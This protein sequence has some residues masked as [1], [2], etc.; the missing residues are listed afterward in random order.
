MTFSPVA[1]SL[2]CCFWNEFTQSPVCL[3]L[4]NQW[5][6]KWTGNLCGGGWGQGVTGHQN[7]CWTHCM[8]SS[9]YCC[10]SNNLQPFRMKKKS[11]LIH[12]PVS[13]C[14]WLTLG[15]HFGFSSC[16]TAPYILLDLPVLSQ[17]NFGSPLQE[18]TE[19][20]NNPMYLTRWGGKEAL[21]FGDKSRGSN[22][23]H[24]VTSLSSFPE[25]YP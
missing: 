24:C 9:C 21:L 10:P 20:Q 6:S 8:I 12:V 14:D 18:I 5:I 25:S 15:S 16:N 17:I 3:P 1:A 4:Y 7:P 22:Q 11:T 19:Y 13:P 23:D 2:L